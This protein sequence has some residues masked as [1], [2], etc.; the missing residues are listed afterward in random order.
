M[1]GGVLGMPWGVFVGFTLCVTG[2]ASWLTGRALANGW[3]PAWHVAPCAVLLALADRF[4]VW[5]LFDGA[6]FP[7]AG[8]AVE[9][10]ALLAIGLLGHRRTRARRMVAQY[11][12]LYERAGPLG[13]RPVRGAGGD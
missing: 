4:L 2:S 13:W 7:A 8:L 11:P 1:T 6:F 5:A 9:T 12:W 3:R 10:A